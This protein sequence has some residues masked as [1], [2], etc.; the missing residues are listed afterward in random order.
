MKEFLHQ[1]KWKISLAQGERTT[2]QA[3][4]AL[5][6]D[7]PELVDGGGVS[8]IEC[9]LSE[10]DDTYEFYWVSYLETLAAAS[11]AMSQ[12]WKKAEIVFC[13]EKRFDVLSLETA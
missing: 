12:S 7:K 3:M 11:R 5:I 8:V 9:G 4:L 2:P 6:R 13:L 10:D 1:G